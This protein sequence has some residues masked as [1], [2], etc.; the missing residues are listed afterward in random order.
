MDVVYA[1]ESFYLAEDDV[2]IWKKNVDFE[3]MTLFT[4]FPVPHSFTKVILKVGGNGSILATMN[5]PTGAIIKENIF[6]FFLNIHGDEDK[7]IQIDPNLKP[8]DSIIGF[9][10]FGEM[11]NFLMLISEKGILKL[12]K[13]NLAAQIFEEVT[14]INLGFLKY[15]VANFFDIGPYGKY[16]VVMTKTTKKPIKAFRSLIGEIINSS[17]LNILKKLRVYGD[18]SKKSSV[19]PFEGVKFGGFFE[20]T[21]VLTAFT[22]YHPSTQMDTFTYDLKRKKFEKVD[23][24]QKKAPAVCA[25]RIEKHDGPNGGFIALTGEGKFFRAWYNNRAEVIMEN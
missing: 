4:A 6:L 17:S 14:E 12:Y 21:L 8:E 3:D 22:F 15:E 19:D 24:Y 9:E 18:K 2:G 20:T 5:K 13:I 7:R 11:K 16:F 10:F 25:K 1:R 23:K